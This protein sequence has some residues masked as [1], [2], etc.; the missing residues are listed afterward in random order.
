MRSLSPRSVLHFVDDEEPTAV[1]RVLGRKTKRSPTK[2]DGWGGRSVNLR[3]HLVC[4]ETIR[5][6]SSSR[7]R[8]EELRVG[9]LFE[10]ARAVVSIIDT[11][12]VTV[13]HLDL[14]LRNVLHI[15]PEV[16]SRL[17]QPAKTH[18]AS[19]SIRLFGDRGAIELSKWLHKNPNLRRLDLRENRI[20]N[21]GLYAIVKAISHCDHHLEVLDLGCNCILD[22]R[23]LPDFL[24][25]NTHLARLDLSYNW[26]G[27]EDVNRLCQGLRMNESLRRLSIMG[28]HRITNR[29]VSLLICCLRDKNTSLQQIEV[30]TCDNSND[31]LQADLHHLLCLNRAGRGFLRSEDSA[32]SPLWPLIFAKSNA[33]FTALFH[34]LRDG[35]TTF[36]GD[37][38]T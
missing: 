4:D 19:L 29:G 32:R 9:P 33:E 15:L 25:R 35:G 11:L 28:C 36:L 1:L 23:P 31:E 30:R 38:P 22:I 37:V 10:S 6:I 12:P 7:Q 17:F 21:E 8:L 18:L 20:G 5:W 3:H 24:Q 34:M 14:D 27:D 26:I 2:S 13:T 16:F